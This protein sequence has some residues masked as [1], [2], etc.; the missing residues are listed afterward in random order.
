MFEAETRE[1][2]EQE[3]L[4]VQR[5]VYVK[6]LSPFIQETVAR[7]YGHLTDTG[8]EPAGPCFVVYHNAVD[9]DSNGPAEVCLP[10]RGV[11]EP[12]GEMRVRLEPAHCEA[13]VRITKGEVAFP[14][15]LRAFDAV[16]DWVRQEGLE[17]AA[18]P[19]EVYFADWANVTDDDPACDVAWPVK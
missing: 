3:V 18:P 10:Y 11:A 19:R 15:I 14:G 8:L 1:V 6:D 17:E 9:D 7:L 4:S 16:H 2:P 13:F 5:N 12:V